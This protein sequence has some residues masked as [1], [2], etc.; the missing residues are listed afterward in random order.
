MFYMI[1]KND[2]KLLFYDKSYKI[3]NMGRKHTE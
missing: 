2:V 1:M 3:M